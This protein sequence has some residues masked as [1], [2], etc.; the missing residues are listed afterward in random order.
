MLSCLGSPRD[1]LSPVCSSQEGAP[2]KPH[3]PGQG[4]TCRLSPRI[5]WNEDRGGKGNTTAAGLVCPRLAASS[6]SDVPWLDNPVQ[7]PG[8][9]SRRHTWPSEPEPASP[10]SQM[11]VLNWTA[12]GPF[13]PPELLS[14]RS[15]CPLP[16]PA[17]SLAGSKPQGHLCHSSLLCSLWAS[18]VNS[19]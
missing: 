15:F 16:S 6:L 4:Q 10:G 19:L 18:P 13:Q 14:L 2:L 1:A 8:F 5:R 12:R 11:G 7:C 9:I 17:P 3:A